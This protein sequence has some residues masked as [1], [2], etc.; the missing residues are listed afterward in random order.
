M[1]ESFGRI[2]SPA[3]T[4]NNGAHG[5]QIVQIIKLPDALN[6]TAKALRLEGQVTQQNANGT[7]RIATTEGEI[8]VKVRGNRPPQVG[9]RVEVELPAGRPPRQATVREA[10]PQQNSETRN[11][12]NPRVETSGVSTRPPTQTAQAVTTTPQGNTTQ[13]T[14]Q[15]QQQAPQANTTPAQS[16]ARPAQTSQPLPPAL[17]EAV[18]QNNS[19]PQT[20]AR[21]LN[22]EAVARLL[23]APPAQA[24]TIAATYQQSL[25]P[26]QQATITQTTFSANI[27]AQN[28]QNQL[29]QLLLQISN[30]PPPTT[31]TQ[32]PVQNIIQNTLQ[33]VA[34]NSISTLQQQSVV[35]LTTPTPAQ[36]TTTLL[37]PQTPTQI[38]PATQ[39]L[40]STSVQNLIPAAPASTNTTQ[41]T[42]PVNAT[43]T[44]APVTFDPANPASLITS[45]TA[46]IDI[47][48]IK[49]TPPLPQITPPAT[50]TAQPQINALPATTQFTPPIISPNSAATITAQVT[51]FTPQ[52]LPL[53]T[54]QLPGSTLPQSFVLQF[55]SNNLQLGSQ[56][57]VIPKIPATALPTIQP[58]LTT[59]PLLQGFQWPAIDDLYNNLL[60][61]NPQTASS[62]TKSLPN[63]GNPSQ[64]GAAAMMFIA[65]VK[66]G[67][68]GNWMGDKKID[69]IRQAGKADIL[70]K[71]TQTNPTARAGAPEA[72]TSSEWRAV[73][74]PMFWEGEIHKITL[75]TRH[76]NQQQQ[77]EQNGHSQTRFIFDL[78]LTRM[79]DVQLDGLLRDNRLDLVI[80]T[81]NAF[82]EPM[83]QTMRQ[84][85]S[86]ALDHTD[87]SGELNFQGSTKNWV[88]VLEQKEELGVSA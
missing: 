51:G 43:L 48:I 50:T 68:L 17:Q 49:I 72:A 14:Q 81:Q 46:K 45:R 57:Q 88:H 56:L 35:N 86:G 8:D 58:Q 39:T 70:S 37:L 77:Q 6:N 19:T 53:V 66:S 55:N 60:Q 9:Q 24:Q 13:Q 74:L 20:P 44:P 67:D 27:T 32:T 38:I 10:P 11:N 69:L 62:L 42:A 1:N 21:P 7:V 79:G 25:A 15:T 65:A 33:P 12:T 23:S 61:I 47:Q 71:L 76:E 73:P 40:P 87:L 54:A 34:V 78:S 29:T 2:S 28:A 36:N 22:A 64:M 5:G 30:S 52:G 85:Y 41:P 18:V 84:A 82:S 26:P 59:N 83:Q 80:R 31:T 75:F 4:A 16:T 63:V 3:P